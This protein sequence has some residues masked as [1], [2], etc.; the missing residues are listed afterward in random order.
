MR[1]WNAAVLV[2]LVIGATLAAP[3]TAGLAQ[4]SAAV[5]GHATSGNGYAYIMKI[6][7]PTVQG[8]PQGVATAPDGTIWFTETAA[9]KIGHIAADGNV[10]EFAL[11]AGSEPKGLAVGPDKNVWFAEQSGKIGRITPSGAIT[12]FPVAGGGDIES[13]T[14][15]PDNALW[16]A[17]RES[18][19]IGR[20]TTSGAIT[21]YPVTAATDITDIARGPGGLWF[22]DYSDNLVGKITTSGQV[23]TFRASGNPGGLVEG[24]DGNEWVAEYSGGD[25]DRVTP[26]GE[27]TRYAL[28]SGSNAD[29][30]SICVGGDNQLWVA[31][32]GTNVLARV[33]PKNPQTSN[34]Y[35]FHLPAGTGPD[36]VADP[37]GT[38][39]A[40]GFDGN[41]II[42]LVFTALSADT[43]KRDI[44]VA[45]GQEQTALKDLASDPDAA[46]VY[47][48]FI[49]HSIG[50]LRRMLDG[51]GGNSPLQGDLNNA[52]QDDDHALDTIIHSAKPG[53][54]A[55]LK[56]YLTA[57][58]AAKQKAESVVNAMVAV[59]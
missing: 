42:A 13:I 2:T 58:I 46:N 33:D 6:A 18:K 12:Q 23:T 24:P 32:E 56:Q 31:E 43:F 50:Q 51:A 21:L 55:A 5:T 25:I 40:G 47:D 1:N 7:L 35:E 30:A 9:S 34:T 45:I 17:V 52:E 22:T 57:G 8:D 11:P 48:E 15:G 29:P 16:F 41:D 28:P 10:T 3:I 44:N 37:N 54:R 26:S 39:V 53:A 27:I 59:G 36:A 19:E 20:I 14:T 38:I 49:I 4:A